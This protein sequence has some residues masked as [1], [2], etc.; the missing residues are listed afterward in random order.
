LYDQNAVKMK[1]ISMKIEPKGK[2]PDAG[3]TNK[4]L[5]YH[6]DGG[7]GLFYFV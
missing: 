6:V 1:Y 5:Q 4:G 7:I 3:M 2:M